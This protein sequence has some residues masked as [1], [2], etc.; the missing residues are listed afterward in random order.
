MVHK[1]QGHFSD[2]RLLVS[3]V[4]M[5]LVTGCSGP[6][7]PNPTEIARLAAEAVKATLTAQPRPPTMTPTL[8]AT[9]TATPTATLMTTPTATATRTPTATAT[10]TITPTAT[11][12]NVPKVIVSSAVNLRSGP[13][14]VYSVIGAAKPG[15]TYTITAK[16]PDGTWVEICCANQGRAWIAASV[17][18]TN[19]DLAQVHVA[20][21]I[22]PTPKAT[23]PPQVQVP[24]GWVK[25]ADPGG[26][27]ITWTP[28]NWSLR[29]ASGW[30]EVTGSTTVLPGQFYRAEFELRDF[31]IAEGDWFIRSVDIGSAK[32]VICVRITVPKGD[33]HVEGMICGGDRSLFE[34]PNPDR[35]TDFRMMLIL[36]ELR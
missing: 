13:G 29:P 8:T 12:T 2:A 19:G 21:E 27:F 31:H 9:P 35:V 4:F 30:N 18:T 26:K 16:I 23:T 20:K 14:T 10:L 32:P 17:V 25:Y 22:P 36:L 15:E 34:V 33:H 11:P 28:K 5:L 7:T 1:S 24:A 6:K 3:L